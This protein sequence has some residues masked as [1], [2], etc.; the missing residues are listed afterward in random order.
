MHDSVPDNTRHG[1]LD[2][3][4]ASSALKD[5]LRS[6][7]TAEG[8]AES[9]AEHSWR[10][11]LFVLCL[12]PE[13]K[14]YDLVKLLKMALLHDL[15][16]AITGDVPAIFQDTDSTARQ[17]RERDGF[18]A[19]I[20]ALEPETRAD[21]LSVVDEYNAGVTK[22]AAFMKGL[23]KL[24]TMLQHVNG[25]NAP[26]FDYAFNLTYGTQWTAEHPLLAALRALVDDKTRQCMADQASP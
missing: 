6:G 24:E 14:D 2:F 9:T 13:L 19:L 7:R 11:A 4:S 10:L 15:G 26:D 21:F 20:S 25:K 17:M 1:L 23:D 18:I 16:E 3:L 22:E 12:E 8:R 5:T